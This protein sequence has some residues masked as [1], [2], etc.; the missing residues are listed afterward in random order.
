MLPQ[1]PIGQFSSHI[2]CVEVR[3]VAFGSFTQR[4]DV[5]CAV[6]E[7]CERFPKFVV[8]L[9]AQLLEVAPLDLPD[10]SDCKL[11]DLHPRMRRH[12]QLRA[13][14]VGVDFPHYVAQSLELVNDLSHGGRADA[15]APRQQRRA[16]PA[17]L[18]VGEDGAVLRAKALV[19]RGIHHAKQ[20]AIEG[21]ESIEEE[22]AGVGLLTRNHD[23]LAAIMAA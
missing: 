4:F 17:R 3:R 12:N 6:S 19:A 23:R 21:L 18:E 11:R 15:S 10:R 5:E 14:I 2:G 8:S 9:L 7:I 13:P 20:F 22:G 16:G 1:V